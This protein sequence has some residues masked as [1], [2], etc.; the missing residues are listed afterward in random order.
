VGGA[1]REPQ[2][3]EGRLDHSICPGCPGLKTVLVARMTGGSY[4]LAAYPHQEPAAFVVSAD[5]DRLRGALQDVFG[6]PTAPVAG[7]SS[8]PAPQASASPGKRVQP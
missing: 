4:L 1:R 7:E 5:A 2:P 3:G 6:Y 8:N